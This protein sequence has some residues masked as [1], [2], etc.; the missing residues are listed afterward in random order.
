MIKLNKSLNAWQTSCFEDV[1]KAEIE[2]LDATLLPLQQALAQGNYANDS[3]FSVMVLSVAD[4]PDF[5]CTKTGI[6]YKG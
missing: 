1:L 6:F 5:I 2:Q 4:E 3:D